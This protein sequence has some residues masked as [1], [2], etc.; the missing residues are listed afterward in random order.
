MGYCKD[1]PVS[2]SPW[3]DETTKE[4]HIFIGLQ[5][6]QF[7]VSSASTKGAMAKNVKN[8]STYP[9]LPCVRFFINLLYYYIFCPT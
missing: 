9:V 2:R 5:M 7:Q 8:G 3:N 1:T 4:T 6:P